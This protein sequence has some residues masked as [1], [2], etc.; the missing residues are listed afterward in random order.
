MIPDE[1]SDLG[2]IRETL[3]LAM[4]QLGATPSIEDFR[5]AY[6][7][8][9]GEMLPL[10]VGVAFEA[11][12]DGEVRG[13]WSGTPDTR[14]DRVVLY[15]HGGGYFAGS[16]RS[17]RLMSG[18]LGRLT[19]ARSFSVD[20]RLAPE[21]PYP[22]ALDD[23]VAAYR[24]LLG[25]GCPPTG[26][27]VAGDSCGAGLAVAVMMRARA[28]GL[29]LPAAAYLVS[30]AVDLAVTQES[31]DRKAD[32]DPTGSRAGLELCASLYLQGPSAP[33]RRDPLVSPMYAEPADLAGFPPVLVH[34][35]SHDVMLDEGL[36]LARQLAMADVATTVQVWPEYFHAFPLWYASLAAGRTALAAAADFLAAHWAAARLDGAMRARA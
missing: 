13:I 6:D 14:H 1:L 27:A 30:P 7:T 23:G 12:Q 20:Y 10:P 21:H 2:A 35:A 17:W 15:F 18:E 16:A 9:F 36:R 11:V 25:Q 26:I 32:V 4:A 24:W 33:D 34:V 29:P 5:R 31:V 22:A 19:R 8:V 3:R 28:A